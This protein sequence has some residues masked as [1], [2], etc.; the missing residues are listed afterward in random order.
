MR[1]AT[2]LGLLAAMT[3]LPVSAEIN[4]YD[5]VEWLCERSEVVARGTLVAVSPEDPSGQQGKNLDLVSLTLQPTQVA[6]GGGATT[7]AL[8]PIYFSMRLPDTRRLMEWKK[9]GTEVVVFLRRT[10]QAYAKDG[11]DYSLWPV[12]ETGSAQ[13]VVVAFAKP[14]V[15]LLSAGE[16]AHVSTPGQLEASCQRSSA[17]PRKSP[18]EEPAGPHLLEVPASSA[19]YDT[20]YSG[21]RCYLNVPVGVF[22]TA[23]PSL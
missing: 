10:V 19:V 17:T 21:S 16:M 11:H 13:Q 6:K 9:A 12:R 15:H 8:A 2:A 4:I 18:L 3:A 14:H 20:L 23:K 1:F 22:K 5:S 7:T